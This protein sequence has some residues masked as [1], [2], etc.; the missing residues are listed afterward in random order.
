MVLMKKQGEVLHTVIQNEQKSHGGSD[1]CFNNFGNYFGNG[2]FICSLANEREVFVMIGKK[3]AT[4][5]QLAMMILAVL[6][7]IFLLVWYGG[8]GEQLGNLVDKIGGLF[9]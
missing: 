1:S 7:L 2:T 4:M 8:L 6:F 3:G 5:W 9:G